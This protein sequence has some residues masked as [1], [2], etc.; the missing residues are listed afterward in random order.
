M[1]E[2]NENKQAAQ[3][4]TFEEQEFFNW[5][6]ANDIDHN[7]EG[8]D[9]DTRKDF[10]KIKRRFATAI[11]EKRLTVDGENIIYT[12]SDKSPNKGKIFNI[13]RPNGRALTAM[14]GLKDTSAN[15]R[16]INFIGAM[17]GVEK[18][19]I[20]EIAQLDLKKDFVILQDI[21]RLFLVD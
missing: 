5:C 13:G 1:K 12:V 3:D 18:R 11:K 21:A 17:C 19:D 7:I 10:E 9:D 4:P 20:S 2:E 6:K 16:T 15:Q 8:M 14:D